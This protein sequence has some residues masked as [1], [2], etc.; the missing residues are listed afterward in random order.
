MTL[1]IVDV[2]TCH[3]TKENAMKYME[4]YQVFKYKLDL[5]RIIVFSALTSSHKHTHT[6]THCRLYES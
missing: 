3:T 6:H 5:V 4:T 2:W 1:E